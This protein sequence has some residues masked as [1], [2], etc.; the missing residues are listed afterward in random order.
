ML[1][2]MTLPKQHYRSIANTTTTQASPA[3][4]N[5]VSLGFYEAMPSG[6]TFWKTSGGLMDPGFGNHPSWANAPG[7]GVP[8]PSTIVLRGG[9]LFA[10]VTNS[11]TNDTLHGRLQ[12]VFMKSQNRNSTDTASS[13]TGFDW[14]T[15]VV[16]A[17][18][19]FSWDIMSMPDAGEYIFPPVLDRQM[20]LKPG[21]D[22]TVTYKVKVQKIDADE[23]TRGSGWYPVWIFTVGQR[24]D[25]SASTSVLGLQF[26]FNISFAMMDTLDS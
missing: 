15:S 3:G 21:D 19:P 9:R 1:W 18:R 6:V 26:G 14:L 20:D 17:A 11:T 25:A 16:A 2:N 10:N 22:F 12:L 5:S 4:I 23:F 7:V 8:E 13:N 24:V